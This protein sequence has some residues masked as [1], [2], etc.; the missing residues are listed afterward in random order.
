MFDPIPLQSGANDSW[1]TQKCL[2]GEWVLPLLKN[3]LFTPSWRFTDSQKRVSNVCV[4]SFLKY[5]QSIYSNG[6][7]DIIAR[8]AQQAGFQL[9]VWVLLLLVYFYIPVVILKLIVDILR[10]FSICWQ[11][12]ATHQGDAFFHYL[13]TV[14]RNEFWKVPTSDHIE[15][16]PSFH[17]TPLH[18]QR[19]APECHSHTQVEPATINPYIFTSTTTKSVRAVYTEA[20]CCRFKDECKRGRYYFKI[21]NLTVHRLHQCRECTIYIR[22][23]QV[24][25]CLCKKRLYALCGRWWGVSGLSPTQMTGESI[26]TAALKRNMWK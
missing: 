26:H 4:V 17:L 2:L 21:W 20:K 12:A 14:L 8:I 13:P 24:I 7:I 22:N 15:H 1:G 6:C 11:Y 16:F 10:K 18:L 23:A 3:N 9:T 19:D 5:T 25:A